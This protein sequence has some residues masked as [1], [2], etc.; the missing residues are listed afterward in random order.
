MKCPKFLLALLLIATVVPSKAQSKKE[1]QILLTKDWVSVASLQFDDTLHYLTD[2]LELKKKGEMNWMYGGEVYPGSWKYMGEE[3]EIH[4]IDNSSKRVMARFQILDRSNQTLILKNGSLYPSTLIFVEK[5]S[6][7][8][9]PD[10]DLGYFPEGNVLRRYDFNEV[11]WESGNGGG[12]SR[13]DGIVYVLENDGNNTVEIIIRGKGLTELWEV[14]NKETEGE[15]VIYTCN[16]KFEMDEL[17]VEGKEVA[18]TGVFT[19]T[20][21]KTTLFISELENLLREYVTSNY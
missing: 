18:R 11:L 10:P 3:N 14:V 2:T 16:L 12:G 20:D 8:V 6:G 13:G 19:F 7:L 15:S 5:G 9:Y 17:I 1:M 21:N 4:L